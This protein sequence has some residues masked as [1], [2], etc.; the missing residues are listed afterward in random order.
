MAPPLFFEPTARR[1]RRHS[2][3]SFPITIAFETKEERASRRLNGAL[4][5]L[6]SHG[7]E[8]PEEL[9]DN[10]RAGDRLVDGQYEPISIDEIEAGILQG[11]SAALGLFVQWERGEL[12]WHDPETGQEIPTFE[13]ER[14]GRL[15][16][17]AR[18][19]ELEAELA[20]R[21]EEG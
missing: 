9:Q 20:K 6:R 11:Y 14:E 1:F 12:R 21:K 18:V 7:V 10:S 2:V 13:Q 19:R 17:Q 3:G 4:E 15:A 5:L 8:I 16:A